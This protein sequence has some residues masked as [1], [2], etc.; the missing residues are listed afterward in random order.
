MFGIP[1][2]NLS[3]FASSYSAANPQAASMGPQFQPSSEDVL[4]SVQNNR[5]QGGVYAQPGAFGNPPAQTTST[6]TF[7]PFG[8]NYLGN[9]NVI[10]A[11]TNPNS[12]VPPSNQPARN[13]FANPG[14]D[15]YSG[16]NP[17]QYAN[18]ATSNNLAQQLGG[19]VNQT[20]NANG[21]PVGPPPQN[22]VDF[23]GADMLNAGLLAQRYA[24]MPREQADAITRAEL[25]QMGPRSS[26][27]GEGEEGGQFGSL[28]FYQP[29]SGGQNFLGQGSNLGSSVGARPR[30]AERGG[31]SPGFNPYQPSSM[32]G[33]A[34]FN[35]QVGGSPFS[36][37]TQGPSGVRTP[38]PNMWASQY[39]NYRIPYGNRRYYPGMGAAPRFQP[40]RDFSQNQMPFTWY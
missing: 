34:N 28:S 8:G 27:M 9:Q 31:T 23:G 29:V 16:Y 30:I 19:S 2:N 40:R 26:G 38:N 11:Q 32:G 35:P 13:P 25:A 14:F 1:Q 5:P 18:I 17:S 6:P 12:F 36:P 20:R 22:M 10:N 39:S 3:Q 37:R 15:S 4:S 24:S 33:G 21:S 7:N